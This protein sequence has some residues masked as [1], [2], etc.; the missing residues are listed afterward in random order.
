MRHQ[1]QF[2]QSCVY[3]LFIFSQDPSTYFPAAEKADRSWEYI[4][5]SQTHECGNRDCGRAIPFLGISVSNFRY[6][7]FAVHV[8]C[9]EWV[10]CTK[11]TDIQYVGEI[12]EYID[13]VKYKCTVWAWYREE[14][15]CERRFIAPPSPPLPPPFRA[16]NLKVSKYISLSCHFSLLTT[17]R[18]RTA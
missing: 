7:F 9:L 5:R 14:R 3:E 12:E 18:Q 16:K 1:F 6:W 10:Y 15:E 2:P 4:N 11:K 8:P 13:K 17:I